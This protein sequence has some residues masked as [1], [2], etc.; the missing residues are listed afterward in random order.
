MRI[1]FLPVAEALKAIR[2]EL[3]DAF[4]RV[5]SG[6]WLILGPE[7]DAFEREFAAYCGVD[8]C[9]GVANGLDA[10]AIALKAHGVRP[11]DEVIVPGHTFIA[12]WLAVAQIGAVPVGVDVEPNSFNLDPGGI[13]AA[14]SPRTA[15]IMPV[16]LYGNPAAMDEINQVAARHGLFVLEDAAQAHGACYRSRRAGSL[17]HAA[18]FSFYP[19]KNLG[20][21]GDGGA[22]VTNDSGLAE[23]ARQYRNYGSS[24]KY[25]HDI[26]GANSR[27]DE[28]Q[29]AFLRVRLRRLD[30][31][32]ARRRAIAA[33]YRERLAGVGD[34]TLPQADG[35]CEHV[36]HLFVVRTAHRD[37]LAAG[38]DARG[39]G[40][41]VHYPRPPHLQPAFAD[42]ARRAAL[43]VSE[44]LAGEVLSLPMWP[45]MTERHVDRI[46]AAVRQVFA[47]L[48]GS[49][50]CG[51]PAPL[52]AGP[53]ADQ[54]A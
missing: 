15:A 33:A 3:D 40:T 16:H 53:P 23:R 29:A 13:E 51:A 8:H 49:G 35:D 5:V 25:V 41:M 54:A 43:P 47:Q 36:Y 18:G 17:G 27:L 42:A 14:L 31:E 46:A 6:G 9:V 28:L 4:D 45:A 12:S 7:V 10:L 44:A 19:T 22:I 32:N 11:G 34:L 37:A 26:A 52:P 48:D 39:I 20:A 38:I 30:E 1:E 21:L 2:G 24:A 50:G